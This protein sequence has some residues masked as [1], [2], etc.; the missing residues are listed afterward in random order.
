MEPLHFLIINGIKVVSP[1]KDEELLARIVEKLRKLR[2][3]E[4]LNTILASVGER[5]QGEICM[6]VTLDQDRYE[7][8]IQGQTRMTFIRLEESPE[9][10]RARPVIYEIQDLVVETNFQ[11]LEVCRS[12]ITAMKR[13]K[14]FLQI[15]RKTEEDSE[16]ESFPG[17]TGTIEFSGDVFLYY[18]SASGKFVVL[19]KI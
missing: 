8:F 17:K 6:T 12:V 3:Y 11:D 10:I 5:P 14:L 1:I 13:R 7:C 2:T 15:G 9:V 16:S 4:S 18:I 19:R